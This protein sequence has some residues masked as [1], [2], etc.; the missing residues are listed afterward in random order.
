MSGPGKEDVMSTSETEKELKE[1]QERKRK[2]EGSTPDGEE[3]GVLHEELAAMRSELVSVGNTMEKVNA[4]LSELS[5]IVQNTNM[6]VI[7]IEKRL[8][9]HDEL[10]KNMQENI[11]TTS[12]KVA[13]IQAEVSNLSVMKA[14]LKSTNKA[15]NEVK[16]SHESL[17]KKIRQLEG[18]AVDQEARSRRNNLIFYGLK[19]AASSSTQEKQE[20]CESLVRAF[21]TKEMAISSERVAV[22]KIVQHGNPSP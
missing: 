9:A 16:S 7:G 22:M 14:D 17:V 11:K 3:D 12:S 1:E 18:R 20:D 6:C 4:T 2:R 10:L 8:N 15:V 21:M 5:I 13:S 19:P